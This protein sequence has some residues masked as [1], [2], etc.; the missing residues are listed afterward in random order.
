MRDKRDGVRFGSSGDS[1]FM[2][3]SL[4]VQRFTKPWASVVLRGCFGGQAGNRPRA[5]LMHPL[6][7][8]DAVRIRCLVIA[9]VILCKGGA[10]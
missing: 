8:S 5:S 10:L 7:E 9:L 4:R 6:G 3:G 1:L 2:P